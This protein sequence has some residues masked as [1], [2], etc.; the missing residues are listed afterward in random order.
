MV[1][2]GDAV[3][4]GQLTEFVQLLSHFLG[5]F[6]RVEGGHGAGHELHAQFGKVGEVLF[7]ELEGDMGGN[8]LYA[9]LLQSLLHVLHRELLIAAGKFHAGIPHLSRAL[10]LVQQGELVF[11]AKGI[12]LQID[13]VH[14]RRTFLA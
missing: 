1:P 12:Q 6:R 7:H 3:L 14:L 5:L 9:G 4:L 8:G 10:D 2:N 13:I 11:K